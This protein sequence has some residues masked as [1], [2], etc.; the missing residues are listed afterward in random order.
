[1]KNETKYFWIGF[2][3]EISLKIAATLKEFLFFVNTMD[4]KSFSALED[5]VS[6][7]TLRA[8]AEMG[9]QKMTEIQAKSIPP[10]LEGK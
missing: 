1:M 4:D 7:Q 2:W 3:S 5:V 8:V 10:L 6:S 9:F